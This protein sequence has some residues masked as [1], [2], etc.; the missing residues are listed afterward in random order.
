MLN[1]IKRFLDL[2]QLNN[3]TIYVAVS[4]GIDSMFLTYCL[5]QLNIKHTI[6]HC[7]FKL[8]GTESDEDENFVIQYAEKHNIKYHSLAFNTKKYCEINH[9]TIQEGARE[10]RYDWFKEFIEKDDAVLFTAHHLDDQ[11]ETFF[12]NLLRG[13]GLKGITGISNKKNKIYRPLLNFSKSEIIHFANQQHI[14]YR[15]DQS[16][17]S[18]NYLRNRLRHH[19]IPELKQETT[20][21]EVK[22]KQLFNELTEI[23]N[24]LDQQINELKSDLNQNQF[25]DISTLKTLPDFLLIRLFNS[26]NLNRK[27]IK[28]FKKFV[29]SKTGSVFKTS[30]HT[31]LK[32]RQQIIIQL[33]TVQPHHQSITINQI[34]FN[35]KYDNQTFKLSYIDINKKIEFNPH[36]AYIDANKINLPITVRK[37]KKGDKIKPLGMRGNKLISDILN[38]KKINR[39]DKDKQLVFESNQQIVWLVDAVVNDS[40]KITNQT[41]QILFIEHIQ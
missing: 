33:K 39:F 30:T 38:D 21:L 34:P 5:H 14:K 11:I 27:K 19:F 20:N 24:Y 18:D 26:F 6:L 37:W 35:L 2:H 10:L 15:E 36:H 4:G 7:N 32:D 28:E 40:F 31:F 9:L 29:D 13:T 3:K 12:I 23:D 17:H 8:R 1:Q 41:Q 25:I 22:F 16:N